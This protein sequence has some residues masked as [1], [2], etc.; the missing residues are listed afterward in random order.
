V[1]SSDLSGFSA[2]LPS[3]RLSTASIDI[4]ANQGEYSKNS[5]I[6]PPI[7]ARQVLP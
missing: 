4:V 1:C 5:D 2:F 7:F 3:L 6:H